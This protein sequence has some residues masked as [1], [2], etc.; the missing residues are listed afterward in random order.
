MGAGE[1]VADRR[2]DR[3]PTLGAEIRGSPETPVV[4][5]GEGPAADPDR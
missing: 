1:H 5:D 4:I 2:E 3:W